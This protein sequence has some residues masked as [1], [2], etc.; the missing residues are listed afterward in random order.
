MYPQNPSTP[1][2]RTSRYYGVATETFVD[3]GGTAHAY[4]ARRFPPPPESFAPIGTHTVVAGERYDTIAAAYLGDPTQFWQLC[5]AN[6]VMDPA[7]LG[8]PGTVV[9]ITLPAGI[10]GYAG[11]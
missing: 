9:T 8:T 10:P 5:D 2:D 4:V 6:A 7:D 11:D 3:A 1:F